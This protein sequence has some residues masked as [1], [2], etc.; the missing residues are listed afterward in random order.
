MSDVE[1]MLT[2][3]T[4]ARHWAT[5]TEWEE[6][7][8][9]LRAALAAATAREGELE[10]E[11]VAAF[12]ALLPECS[13]HPG[14]P[15]TCHP[16]MC[17]CM[18]DTRL[19]AVI[20]VARAE[21]RAE[22]EAA[23]LAVREQMAEHV[24]CAMQALPDD[25]ALRM[26]D[27]GCDDDL[28]RQE[29]E[30]LSAGCETGEVARVIAKSR[31]SRA[32]RARDTVAKALTRSFAA[33]PMPPLPTPTSALDAERERVV[34]WCYLNLPVQPMHGGECEPPDEYVARALAAAKGG[35]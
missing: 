35:A 10:N 30:A 3:L 5:P 13:A 7:L 16:E 9:A 17:D 21:E 25:V 24:R 12:R 18:P 31:A 14:V 26:G 6:M 32:V 2:E 11:R 34:R 23:V 28:A 33:T 15:N 19:P 22:R 8:T 1:R 27:P 20:E 29:A 4:S